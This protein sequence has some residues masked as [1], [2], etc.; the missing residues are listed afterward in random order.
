[1]QF[2]LDEH[3]AHAIAAGLRR[4]GIDVTTTV[5]AGLLG[6]SD[7]EHI[8]FA[9]R[10]ARVIVTQDSDFLRN[11]AN[12]ATHFGIAYYPQGERSFGEVIRHYA[13]A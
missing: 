8:A 13:Y 9:K 2:H 7:D 1:M 4:R 3:V 10:E 12:D 6:A 11:A 5:D